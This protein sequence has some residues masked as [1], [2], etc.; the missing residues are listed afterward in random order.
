MEPTVFLAATG[1]GV[2]RAS[3]SSTG[4]CPVTEVLRGVRVNCLA[5]SPHEPD[6]VLAGTQGN[7]VLRSRDGGLTWQPAGLEGWVVKSLAASPLERD[8]F[9]AG[10][11]PAHVFVSRDGGDEWRDLDAFQ[12]IPS[13]PTWRS[14]AEPPY[15]GYVQTLA[16][17]PTDPGVILA[18][19][20]AGGVMRSADGGQTW[21]DLPDPLRDSHTLTFHATD[22]NWAY[23][24]GGD[25]GAAVSRDA[26]R[27]WEHAVEGLD[28]HYGWACAADP[29]R[30]EV[31]YLSAAPS[32]GHAHYQPDA[33]A[34]IFRRDGEGKWRAL[35]GGLPL[36]LRAMPFMLATN[37]SQPGA[38]YA[39][40]S[41]GEVWHS[42]DYGETWQ[43]LPFNLGAIRRSAVILW[44]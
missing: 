42:D 44:G 6:L 12:A 7:G 26:G 23:Q 5:A 19:I 15:I 14:P 24:G 40:L 9:Y 37:P 31:F 11:K 30:P 36:P 39:G 4:D 34:A 29:A 22:G 8:V 17:S 16:L 10:T 38:V 41:D 28:R 32:A 3:R 43:R 25:G 13:L 21:A 33:L 20:E 2:T 27:T 35:G 1:E 18:G